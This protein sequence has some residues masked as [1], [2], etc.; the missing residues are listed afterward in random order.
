MPI[1]DDKLL[2]KNLALDC[3]KPGGLFCNKDFD[4]FYASQ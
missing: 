3:I 2:V 1:Y 4:T